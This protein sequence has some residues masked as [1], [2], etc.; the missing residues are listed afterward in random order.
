M[1][2]KIL[3]VEDHIINQK[4]AVALLKKLG[5]IVE[6]ASNGEEAVDKHESNT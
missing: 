1:S 2:L 4:M 6:V 5:F 3:L